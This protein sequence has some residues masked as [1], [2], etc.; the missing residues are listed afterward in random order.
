[1]IGLGAP[2]PWPSRPGPVLD[3]LIGEGRHLRYAQDVLAGLARELTLA[4]VPVERITFNL[5]ILHPQNRAVGMVWRAGRPEVETV[6]VG[7]G[8][9]QTPQYQ[10]SPIRVL[11]EG[12]GGLRQR[13]DLEIEDLPFPIYREL[14][15]EGFTD[16]VALPMTFSDGGV[17][18]ST[19]ATRRPGGFAS[20]HICAIAD[21]LPVLALILEAR[22]IRRLARTLLD[23]YVG[24]HAGERILSGQIRRGTGETVRA[25]VWYCD[26]RGFTRL[27]EITPRDAL[28]AC[29]ND[30]FECMATEI[31]KA[32]GE[33][34]KFMGDGM[35][36]LFPLE[37][38][39]ACARALA[40]AE[41]AVAGM[42]GLNERRAQRGEVALGFGIALHAGEVMYGNIGAPDRLDFTVIGPAVNQAARIE[43]LCRDLDRSVL[44]SADFARIYG[45]PLVSLGHHG[46]RGVPEPALVFTLPEAALRQA[47]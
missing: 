33:I 12:A 16:Y 6:R 20:Q 13:L 21:L 41:G 26:L 1:V 27:T 7:H 2:A 45:G 24:H 18:G 34:L 43:K 14:Q 40:A 30:Y 47:G 11:F 38:P 46:L 22:T 23:T 37:C 28:I 10:D 39:D 25:A 36:A 3:W 8:I 29:L 5:R 15:A 42:A 31:A 35:L 4:G 32:D 17:H 44:I 19:W 9:E